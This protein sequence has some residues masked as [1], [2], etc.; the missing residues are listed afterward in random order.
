MLNCLLSNK[1]LGEFWVVRSER[2]EQST[3][4]NPFSDTATETVQRISDTATETVQR[5]SYRNRSAIQLQ[6]SVQRYSYRNHAYKPRAY[7][8]STISPPPSLFLE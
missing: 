2:S 5:Y 7:I 8:V 4:R 1:Q 3:K 6:K